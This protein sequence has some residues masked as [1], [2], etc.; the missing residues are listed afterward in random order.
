MIEDQ[1]PEHVDWV[2][3][4]LYTGKVTPHLARLLM[5]EDTIISTCVDVIEVTAFLNK[6][7]TYSGEDLIL[8]EVFTEQFFNA[9][10]RAYSY[11]GY[12]AE[13]LRKALLFFMSITRLGPTRQ[14]SFQQIFFEHKEFLA[15]V[16]KHMVDTEV[17]I[18]MSSLPSACSVC[19]KSASLYS[20]TWTYMCGQDIYTLSGVCQECDGDLQGNYD[21][22]EEKCLLKMDETT[23]LNPE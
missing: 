19:K 11:D 5:S 13:L 15:D 18:V 7:R 14:Y 8:P 21:Y 4:F 1:E 2:L 23:A 17:G 3:Y 22:D 12:P 20:D 10:Q 16:L 9:A 6:T